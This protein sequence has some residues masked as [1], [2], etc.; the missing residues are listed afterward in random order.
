[1]QNNAVR[2]EEGWH[3]Q[4]IRRVDQQKWD[5]ALLD[6]PG[7]MRCGLGPLKMSVDGV[8]QK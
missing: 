2:G 5:C 3:P 1:M 4:S 8:G 6:F 7:R